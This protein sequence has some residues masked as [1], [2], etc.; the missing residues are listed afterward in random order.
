VPY[1]GGAQAITDLIGGQ[2]DVMFNGMVATYPHV[3]AGKAILGAQGGGAGGAGGA[4]IVAYLSDANLRGGQAI[5]DGIVDGVRNRLIERGPE[6]DEAFLSIPQRARDILQIQSPSKVF[7]E[8]G[9]QIG[10]GMAEGIAASSEMVRQAVS[11]M[12]TGAAEG[13]DNATA[14]ILSAMGS[15]FQGSKK[16]SAGIALANSWLA[17][18]EVLKDPAYIGRPW[19]RFAA[20]AGA[21]S[22]GLAAVRAINSASAGGGGG[23]SAS[24]TGSGATAGGGQA[25]SI[26]NITLMGDNFSAGSVR[27]LIEQINREIENGANF[28]GIR[29]A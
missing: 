19:A 1:K 22:S 14:S 2:V 13:A 23:G 12:S 7:E 6:L 11:T 17:F 25:G 26:A 15:L 21:L 29:V 4:G 20:A 16:I 24:S 28:A 18:T 3:K 8:I 10:A 5:G 9:G 27:V